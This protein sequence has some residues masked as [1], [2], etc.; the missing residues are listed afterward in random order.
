MLR[1]LP[2]LTLL[3]IIGCTPQPQ[4]IAIGDTITAEFAS[5][6]PALNDGSRYHLYRIQATA[7]E[8][9]TITQRSEEV[10]SYLLISH[11]PEFETTDFQNDDFELFTRD[12]QI[13]FIGDG[14]PYFIVASTYDGDDF[15]TY[16]LSVD[17]S[18]GL[19]AIHLNGATTVD[20]RLTAESQQMEDG[21]HYHCYVFATQ[22]ETEYTM[23]LTSPDFDTY[24]ML[25]TGEFCGQAILQTTENTSVL[26]FTAE[27]DSYFIITNSLY[28]D[29]QGSYT[30]EIE[31]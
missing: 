29:L 30:L 18:P 2:F 1:F 6:D 22:S 12:S 16:S 4:S 21:S 5:S 24:L 8:I 13:S 14:R 23:S 7:G 20:N 31:G 28:P 25:S 19:V 3:L 27:R 17:N 11:N 10:D 15:G 26:T 9:V